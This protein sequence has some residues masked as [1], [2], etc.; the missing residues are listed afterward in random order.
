MNHKVINLK[1]PLFLL[2]YLSFL[3]SFLLNQRFVCNYMRDQQKNKG[4]NWGVVYFNKAMQSRRSGV[5]G[6]G[7]TALVTGRLIVCF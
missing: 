1:N 6:G 7:G 4:G 2:L 3:L 5:G